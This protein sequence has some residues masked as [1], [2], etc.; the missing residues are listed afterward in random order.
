MKR[1]PGIVE[2][3]DLILVMGKSLAKGLP[4]DK[5]YVITEFF[6]S[7]GRIRNPWPD[8]GPRAAERYRQCLNELRELIEPNA[9]RLLQPLHSVE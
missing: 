3:A 6:G 5:T 2:D 4:V 1:N 7:T 9:D 8:T